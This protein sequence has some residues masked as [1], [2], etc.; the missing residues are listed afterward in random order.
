MLGLTNRFQTLHKDS[1]DNKIRFGKRKNYYIIS[2][3]KSVR[4]FKTCRFFTFFTTN[5]YVII[6]VFNENDLT[7]LRTIAE[8]PNGEVDKHRSIRILIQLCI[9]IEDRLG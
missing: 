8:V 4:P 1:Y 5:F 3:R 2:A 6:K 9:S 7:G